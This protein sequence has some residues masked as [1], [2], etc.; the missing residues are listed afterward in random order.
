MNSR[1]IMNYNRTALPPSGIQCELAMCSH[2]TPNEGKVLIPNPLNSQ[3]STWHLEMKIAAESVGR[4]WW[5]LAGWKTWFSNVCNFPKISIIWGPEVMG[6]MTSGLVQDVLHVWT[7]VS[8]SLY[9]F[10]HFYVL[11]GNLTKEKI[12]CRIYVWSVPW[13]QDWVSTWL[14]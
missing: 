11:Q 2:R 5:R 14:D 10:W 7:L 13:W 8:Q 4:F 3:I 1:Q 12:F 6:Q 9:R